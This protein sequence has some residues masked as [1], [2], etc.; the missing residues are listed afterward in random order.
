MPDSVI[1]GMGRNIPLIHV[2][3]VNAVAWSEAKYFVGDTLLRA[4]SF[5]KR[6]DQCIRLLDRAG[7]IVLYLVA[8]IV[9]WTRQIGREEPHIQPI[10]EIAANKIERWPTGLTLQQGESDGQP[11]QRCRNRV[12]EIVVDQKQQF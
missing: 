5:A 1:A 10:E 12:L 6:I 8:Q 7:N 9:I 11:L 4:P 2:N 3:V